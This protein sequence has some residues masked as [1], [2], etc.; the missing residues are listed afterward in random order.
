MFLFSE[1][2]NAPSLEQSESQ[3]KN[4][5]V[6]SES[7]LAPPPPQI[8]SPSPPPPPRINAEDLK[9][10]KKR[11]EEQEIANDN[12]KKE[13]LDKGIIQHFDFSFC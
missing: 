8:S 10:G 7:M 11:K 1:V 4:D 13:K 6:D 2:R 3:D 9:R 12:N 5:P